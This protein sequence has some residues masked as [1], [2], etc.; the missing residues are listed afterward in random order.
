MDT[1]QARPDDLP[2]PSGGLG[3]RI[4]GVVLLAALGTAIVVG[5]A[6][7]YSVY[8]PLRDRIEEVSARVLA[9]SAE[10]LV[11][12]LDAVRG[13]IGSVAGQP[14]W[15]RATL[16]A[17]AKNRRTDREI[18]TLSKL[19]IEALS[20]VSTLSALLVL[21]ADGE[22]VVA[23]GSRSPLG[24]LLAQLETKNVLESDLMEFSAVCHWPAR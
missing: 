15:Q 22:V 20:G 3:N 14:H 21:D 5:G 10:E 18:G 2:W 12:V 8:A 24:G 7:L 11:E 17:S 23:A 9:G 6:A 4:A 16:A 1:N 19:L 13:E